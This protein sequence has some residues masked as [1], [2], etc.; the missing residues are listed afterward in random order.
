MTDLIK[1]CTDILRVKTEFNLLEDNEVYLDV[2][3]YP[4]NKNKMPIMCDYKTEVPFESREGYESGNRSIVLYDDGKWFKAKGI[5]IP[6]GISRPIYYENK[7]FTYKLYG[8]LEMCHHSAL[9]GFMEKVDLESERFGAR[10][11]SELDVTIETSG[12]G[13]YDKTYYNSYKDRRELF[14]YL[15]TTDE[16]KRLTNL[17]DS[18]NITQG[19]SFYSYI[20]SDLRVNEILYTFMF[21][22][23]KQILNPHE[24][25]D[26]I[27]W[28]GS[29]CGYNL[30]KLHDG[31]ILHG[32]WIGDK[33]ADMGLSDV[34][35]NSYTGNHTL[36][37]KETC[38]VDFDLAQSIPSDARAYMMDLEKWCLI[39]MENPLHYA[40]SYLKNDALEMGLAKKNVFREEL[41][42]SFEEGVN[43]GYSGE[44]YYIENK[45]R[46][47]MLEKI[48]K[49]KRFLWNL[50]GLPKDLIGD[51]YYIDAL[52]LRKSMKD[53]EIKK[54]VNSLQL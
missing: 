21:P 3:R 2:K 51:I 6:R 54:A 45:I 27:K 26:Y 20:P 42:K 28:L 19:F 12:W 53:I 46:K 14:Q 5:G 24:C 8:D 41:A 15:R 4:F 40:G 32:T 36:T 23:I 49:S 13:S 44:I 50:Y 38:L 17:L 34:H 11:A 35:S 7:I 9:W 1:K 31:N 30:K 18:S 25:I 16:D 52:L 37:E 39:N 47:S 43:E 29:S 48:A 33:K 10:K 22:Q